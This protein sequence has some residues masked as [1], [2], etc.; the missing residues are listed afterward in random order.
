MDSV[1]V[2]KAVFVKLICQLILRPGY[3]MPKV[4]KLS[5]L[6]FNALI[7]STNF[8]SLILFAESAYMNTPCRWPN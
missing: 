5:T 6:I 4:L 1:Q 3:L 7:F 2:G 8:E